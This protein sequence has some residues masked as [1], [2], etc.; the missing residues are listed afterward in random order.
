MV[1]ASFADAVQRR[2][3]G[4]APDPERDAVIRGAAVTRVTAF[5]TAATV[6]LAMGVLSAQRPRS[7]FR[8]LMV[9]TLT[10]DAKLVPTAVFDGKSWSAPWIEAYLATTTNIDS[11][12]PPRPATLRDIPSARWGGW[13]PALHWELLAADGTRRAIQV[14]GVTDSTECTNNVDASLATDLPL[15]ADA[16]NPDR[17][18]PDPLAGLA[19]SLPGLLE[20]VARLPLD[21]RDAMDIA[22]LLPATFRRLETDVWDGRF[23]DERRA[24]R[25]FPTLS[26]AFAA[27]LPDGRT[28]LLFHARW[29]ISDVSF[30][31]VTLVTGWCVRDGTS[32]LRVV[33]AFGSQTDLD[34]KVVKTP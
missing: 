28:V 22:G 17:G 15:A 25:S 32:P 7:P 9:G 29:P 12:P 20:P 5:A 34:G 16:A 27:K 4:V 24:R 11:P 2:T 30:E 19:S 26:D 33:T 14:R 21:G 31:P 1:F 10:I 13:R 23:Q 8:G 6:L 18:C 3:S